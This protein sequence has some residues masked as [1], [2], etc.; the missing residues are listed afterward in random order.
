LLFERAAM[1]I[2]NPNA[3]AVFSTFSPPAGSG[4]FAPLPADAPMDCCHCGSPC[5]IF[6]YSDNGW[7]GSN[8]DAVKFSN[9]R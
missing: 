9:V 7:G 4:F 1:L 6:S 2:G 3:H 5:P 8:I